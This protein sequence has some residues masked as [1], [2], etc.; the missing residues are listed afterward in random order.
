MWELWGVEISGF[1]LTW[2]IADTT[3]WCYRTSRDNVNS[4]KVAI[5][6]VS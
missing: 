1:S 6:G 3:A 5:H 4:V 2:H